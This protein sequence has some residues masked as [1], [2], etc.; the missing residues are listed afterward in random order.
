M[1]SLLG[2]PVPSAFILPSSM[3]KS[4]EIFEEKKKSFEDDILRNLR[5][6]EENWSRKMGRPFRYGA[7]PSDP[8]NPE[9]E[10]LFLSIR[11]GSVFIMPGISETAVAIGFSPEIYEYI[12]K[13]RGEQAGY[14]A[15]ISFVESIGVS[16]GIPRE[17]FENV[18]QK[19]I[20]DA[21]NLG[22][23]YVDERIL[24]QIVAD[25]KDIL[26]DGGVFDQFNELYKNPE[27]QLLS[28]IPIIFQSW[29][30]PKAKR[31][32]QEKGISDDWHTPVI[33]Q[34]YVFGD[35]DEQSGSGTAL[36]HDRTGEE[37]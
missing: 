2:L 21:R 20:S 34:A 36:S 16:L 25:M 6:L 1:G 12:L 13:T 3:G 18:I 27:R 5:I 26:K 33:V 11:S 31:Y 24:A 35:R 8:L 4:L 37:F 30:S 7:I 10:P 17:K 9:F 19:H 28:L 32:R 22:L 14:K 29:N 15:F 23:S